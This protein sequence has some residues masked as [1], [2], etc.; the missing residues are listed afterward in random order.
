ML[1]RVPERSRG[2]AD[3][4]DL[5]AY[6]ASGNRGSA[7]D[8]RDD[9]DPRDMRLDWLAVGASAPPLALTSPLAAAGWLAE[10]LGQVATLHEQSLY[11]HTLLRIDA[12]YGDPAALAALV[13]ATLGVALPT[14][15]APGNRR[16]PAGHWR[17]HATSLGDAFALL[18]P[19]AQ[20]LG[21]E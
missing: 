15:P 1:G 8:F 19:V 4:C 7:A 3:E 11:P 2:F 12:A 16:V 13:G 9:V 5:L 18:T 17:A 21:Y 20:R 6:V 14:P 10:V